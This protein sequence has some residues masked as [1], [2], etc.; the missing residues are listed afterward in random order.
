VRRRLPSTSE[1]TRRKQLRKGS[2]SLRKRR[3]RTRR[4]QRVERPR[5]GAREPAKAVAAAVCHQQ[6]R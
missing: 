3:A 1:S 5:N 2:W 4:N 6:L